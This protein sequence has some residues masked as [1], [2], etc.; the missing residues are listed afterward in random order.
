[1]QLDLVIIEE[2]PHAPVLT[3]PAKPVA[4][5]L[6]NEDRE[7][8][9]ALKAKAL[10]LG[11]VGLAAPQVG[12]PKQII[13]FSINEQAKSL[14]KNAEVVPLTV[15]INPEYYPVEG[16]AILTDWEGCFSVK[17]TYGKVP[18]Y[19]KIYYSAQTESGEKISGIAE[20]FTA[21][22]LQ[23]EIDHLRGLLIIDR[24]TPDCVYGSP[25][26][27]MPLRAK[28]FRPEQKRIFDAVMAKQKKD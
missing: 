26:D 6:S 19:E 23:H 5:P 7:F 16:S 13:A 17:D 10:S 27:M 25:K 14:R 3:Q 2:Q 18:R 4:F 28:E 20:G 11:G 21:R 1:M 12:V 24:L 8:I 9:A 22:V 15:F